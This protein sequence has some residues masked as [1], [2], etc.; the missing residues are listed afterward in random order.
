MDRWEEIKARIERPPADRPRISVGLGTCSIAAGAREVLLEVHLT[1]RRLGIPA[2]VSQ[3]G[4]NGMCYREVLVDITLP[5]RP[6]ITY[7]DITPELV[8]ELLEDCLVRGELRPDLAVGVVDGPGYQGIPAYHE[9]PFFR[10]QRRIALRHCGLID[11][12]SIDDYIAHGGYAAFAKALFRMTP[13][14]VIEEVKR[15][16]LRGRGGAGFPTGRK[17][18]SCRAAS[19][20]PKYI[21]CNGEEGEPSIFK[22]R[23]IMEGDPHTVIEGM[24]IAGYA[25][26]AEQGFIYIAGECPLAIR[27]LDLAIRQ[28]EAYN[29]LGEDILG[30]GFSFSIV[31]RQGAG[32]YVSGESSALMSSIEGK[33]AMPRVKIVRSVERGLWGKPTNM[34][35][36]ET[37]ANIPPII[38]HGGEWYARLGTERSKG[39]K[40]FALTGNVVHTGLVEV[41]MGL[42]L[43]R[44]V[45]DIGGGIAEGRA[46]K[47]AQPGGPSGGVLPSS[48]LDLPISYEALQEVGSAMGA[49][50]FQVL[51]ETACMVELAR[52][53]A[54]FN[55]AESCGR[56]SICRLGTQRLHDLLTRIC[57]GRG[58][59]EDLEH[60]EVLGRTMIETSLCGLGQSAPLP[61]LSAVRHF[62]EEF[63]AHIYQRRCPAGVC[64][65]LVH[66]RIL[67][68]ECT[69]CGECALVC[70][71][72]AIVGEP[73]R[74]YAIVDAQ[75]LR[76]GLCPMECPQGAI[77]VGS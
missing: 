71:S 10:Y 51:D 65:A 8:P 62:R 11:P 45:F 7:G 38:E 19:G 70:P 74:P 33:R 4:C 23:R 24:L 67:A 14:E 44:L 52:F 47:A 3:T 5:D 61:V 21:I 32:S 56:C 42:P 66:Y 77:V 27:R 16:G 37:F 57:E 73:E 54:E 17:W 64:P 41:P 34:N 75:C 18:E 28:A 69:G 63:E 43:R 31:I 29:L 9:L 25:I 36:V 58:Q 22:D 59:P 13:E 48:L 35:N 68:E 49:G 76:C 6:R 46:F 72:G 2:V 30:S 60:I 40:V 39:T 50:G 20:H 55:E 1:L 12:Q 53:F 26:G 15:S